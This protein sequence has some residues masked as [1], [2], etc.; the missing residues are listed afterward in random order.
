MPLTVSISDAIPVDGVHVLEPDFWPAV[1]SSLGK[2]FTRELWVTVRFGARG[3][4]THA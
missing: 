3:A 2:P 4:T 1:P